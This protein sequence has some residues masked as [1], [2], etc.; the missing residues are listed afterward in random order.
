MALRLFEVI[1]KHLAPIVL[2]ILLVAVL[3]CLISVA[4]CAA[5]QKTINE[6]DFDQARKLV[7]AMDEAGI[8]GSVTL[9]FGE[10]SVFAKQTFGLMPGVTI[11]VHM[12]ANPKGKHEEIDN[13]IGVHDPPP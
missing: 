12:L 13:A 5:M 6:T 8:A 1:E 7:Q 10:F 3:W 4:G 11:D 9:K 2:G